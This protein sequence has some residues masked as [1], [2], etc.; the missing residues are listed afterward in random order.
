MHDIAKL[1][2]LARL[3]DEGNSN[4]I[5]SDID[6]IM[7]TIDVI[8]SAPISEDYQEWKGIN[9]P[10]KLRQDNPQPGHPGLVEKLCPEHKYGFVLTPKVL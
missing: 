2:R 5:H 7:D 4:T 1:Y 8:F 6:N 9:G 3:N 10:K